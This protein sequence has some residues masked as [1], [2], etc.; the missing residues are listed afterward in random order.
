MFNDI[1]IAITVPMNNEM[2]TTIHKESTPNL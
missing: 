1:W 2:I